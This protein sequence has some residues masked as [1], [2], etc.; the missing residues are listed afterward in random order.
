MKQSP[1]RTSSK[2]VTINESQNYVNG[3]AIAF[4]SHT[5][6]FVQPLDPFIEIR[7]NPLALQSLEYEK[8]Y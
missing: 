2:K 7:F 5:K 1:K 3:A 8:V 6:R 4:N